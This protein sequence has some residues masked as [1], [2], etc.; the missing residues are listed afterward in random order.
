MFCC[1]SSF[2]H[3]L[4]CS[5][6]F[7]IDSDEDEKPAKKVKLGKN[8]ALPKA[9]APASKAKPRV[10]SNPRKIAAKKILESD[11][12]EE[13]SAHIPTPPPRDTGPKRTARA[14]P[15]K[16]IEIESDGDNDED[17]SFVI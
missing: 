14:Q 9:T 6:S 11:I 16:Y 17:D 1:L 2:A 10:V 4:Y 5:D 3:S 7:T 15:K 13:G 12:E 8:D